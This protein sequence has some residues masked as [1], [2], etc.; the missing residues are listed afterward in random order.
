MSPRRLLRSQPRLAAFDV[1][2]L[3]FN[4]DDHVCVLAQPPSVDGK[5]RLVAYRHVPGG[6]VPTALCA[7]RRWGL[8][9]AYVGPFGDD[10]GGRRQREA[11]IG[12][13]VDVSACR[14]R[15][16][17]GSQISV[18]LVD[19]RTGER[20]VLWT[21]PDGLALRIDE[22]DRDRLTSG[23]ALLLDAAEVG[24]AIAAAGWAREAGILV[25]LDVDNPGPRTDEL[26]A[27]S[28]AVIVSDRFARDHTGIA[29]LRRALRAMT[30]RGPWLAAATLG[31]GGA[32]AWVDGRVLHVPAIP[33][34]VTDSTSAGDLFHA[35]CLYGLLHGWSPARS[36]GFASAAAALACTTLG[37]RP[38][39]PELAAVE[40]LAA[41][42]IHS[43]GEN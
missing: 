39:I 28:D 43:A 17:V 37:G 36:L 13:G 23:R 8:R 11:L 21:R 10:A 7:L 24:T 29:D 3:G 22:L 12:E 9:T 27:L 15:T 1:V 4:T 41:S 18:I 16:G 26:L 42:R 5:Q 25:M 20:T 38:S 2:G 31:R 32:L 33:I 6:Q 40:A 14:A 30:A 19:Q 34:P 35:G